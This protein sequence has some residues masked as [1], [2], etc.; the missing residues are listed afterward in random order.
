MLNPGVLSIPIKAA[1]VGAT[2]P[3]MNAKKQTPVDPGA[4]EFVW[5]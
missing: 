5:K 1:T 3:S 2:R 4:C